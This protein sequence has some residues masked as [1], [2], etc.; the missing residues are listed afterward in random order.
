MPTKEAL[1]RVAKTIRDTRPT[2][3]FGRPPGSFDNT[4]QEH[5]SGYHEQ[6]ECGT[7]ND[8]RDISF[9]KHGPARDR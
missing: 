9:V 5:K 4:Q 1:T 7:E 3:S 6:Y 8:V 2:V